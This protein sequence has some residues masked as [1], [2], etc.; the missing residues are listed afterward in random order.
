MEIRL[1]K[2]NE[3]AKLFAMIKSSCEETMSK[4]YPERS[5]EY[6]LTKQVNVEALT[7]RMNTG[8]FYI[9][10]E[11]DRIIGC[12]CVKKSKT[13][14]NDCLFFTIF[15]APDCQGKGIGKKIIETL[16]NDEYTKNAKR[17]EISAS[18]NAVPFYK[19]CGYNHKNGQLTYDDGMLYLEKFF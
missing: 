18:L 6:I 5:I 9:V 10:A 3:I 16:E 8:H 12:G 4:Y 1:V 15:V 19:R 14:E 13:N 2:E 7:R 11:Q 17:V